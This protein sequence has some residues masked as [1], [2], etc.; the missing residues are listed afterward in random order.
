MDGELPRHWHSRKQTE[1]DLCPGGTGAGIWAL[2][3]CCLLGP[4]LGICPSPIR[5]WGLV[6]VEPLPQW[7]LITGTWKIGISHQSIVDH[8]DRSTSRFLTVS[9]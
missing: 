4:A 7:T 1:Q 3:M 2:G 9:V 5:L 8:R 6:L